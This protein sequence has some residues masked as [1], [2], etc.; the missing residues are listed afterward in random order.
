L[1]IKEGQVVLTP[2]ICASDENNPIIEIHRVVMN[3]EATLQ[4]FTPLHTLQPFPYHDILSIYLTS[5]SVL[6]KPSLLF[7]LQNPFRRHDALLSKARHA[8]DAS[9][10][11]QQ[12]HLHI[13]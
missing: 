11:V 6:I 9:S 8:E 3:I 10:L 1:A 12:P 13:P 5:S 7:E 2:Y 4:F